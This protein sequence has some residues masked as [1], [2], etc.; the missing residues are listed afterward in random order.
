MI[1]ADDLATLARSSAKPIPLQYVFSF[2]GHRRCG[3][4]TGAEVDVAATESVGVKPVL[5]DVA[6]LQA[7]WPTTQ[8]FRGRGRR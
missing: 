6:T 8:T 7:F 3:A 5:T 1:T 4:T 2:D